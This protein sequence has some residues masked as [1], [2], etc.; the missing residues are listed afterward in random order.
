MEI[1]ELDKISLTLAHG[2]RFKEQ[3][4]KAMLLKG[5]STDDIISV[6]SQAI[7]SLIVY[8]IFHKNISRKIVLNSESEVKL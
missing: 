2:D 1:V 7:N 4:N 8:E 3:A 6:S 5:I